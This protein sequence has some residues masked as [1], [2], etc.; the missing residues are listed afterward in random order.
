MQLTLIPT[1]VLQGSKPMNI[2]GI[3]VDEKFSGKGIGSRMIMK[4]IYFALKNEVKI[5]QLT[6]NKKR[7]RAHEFYKKLGLESSHEGMKLKI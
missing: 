3:R 2:E 4:A 5:I 7:T 6:T 1:I